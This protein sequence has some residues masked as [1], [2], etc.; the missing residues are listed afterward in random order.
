MKEASFE[1]LT[2]TR[3]HELRRT[4]L[5]QA[6]SALEAGHPELSRSLCVKALKV[7][8]FIEQKQNEKINDLFA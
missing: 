5:V 7:E 1:D 3:L 8:K 6:H 2:L 4:W